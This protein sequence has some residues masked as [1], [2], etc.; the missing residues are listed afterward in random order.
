MIGYEMGVLSDRVGGLL[1]PQ[2]VTELQSAA[3][4]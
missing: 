4:G 3:T 1:T 2:L